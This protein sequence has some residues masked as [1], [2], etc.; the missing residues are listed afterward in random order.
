[1]DLESAMDFEAA[2]GRLASPFS[3]APL[4]TFDGVCNTRRANE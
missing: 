3:S 4:L 2:P 1:M